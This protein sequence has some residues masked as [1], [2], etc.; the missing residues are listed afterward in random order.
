MKTQ[1]VIGPEN[2]ARRRVRASFSLEGLQAVA[3]NGVNVKLG[4]IIFEMLN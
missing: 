3:V 2:I 1:N 4:R